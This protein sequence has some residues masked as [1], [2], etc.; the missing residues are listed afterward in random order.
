M[1]GMSC[2]NSDTL[3][4]ETKNKMQPLSLGQFNNHMKNLGHNGFYIQRISQTAQTVEA[5]IR[6][7]TI[8]F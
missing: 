5:T 1:L 3:H 8:I 7:A 2:H 4:Q 6:V